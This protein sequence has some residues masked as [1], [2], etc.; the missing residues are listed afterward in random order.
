MTA[1]PAGRLLQVLGVW[2]GIAAIIGN[3]IGIGIMRT[4]SD[5]AHNLPSTGAYL[6]AWI[7]GGIY[8]AL[9]AAS[10]AELGVM[11]PRSGGQYV[12]AAEVFGPYAGFV[13]GWTDWLSTAASIAAVSMAMSE[14]AAPFVAISTEHAW[15][16]AVLT[17]IVIT[18]LLWRGTKSSDR[19]VQIMTL[20]K[21]IALV[22]VPLVAFAM[23]VHAPSAVSPAAE[24]ARATPAFGIGAVVLAMQ[25]VIYSYDGWNGVLYFSGEVTDPARDI[26]RSMLGGVGSVMAIYLLL[27][28]SFVYVLGVDGVAATNFPAGAVAS[29]L[30]GARGD[31]VIRVVVVLS[32]L[33]ALP[34]L[35]LMGSRVPHAMSGDGLFP[36]SATRVSE[37]GTPTVTL[38]ITL[39]VSIAFVVSGTF[40]QAIAIAAFFFVLQYAMSFTAV[41]VLRRRAPDRARPYRAIGY[42][43]TTA[44]SLVGALAFLVGA[45]VQDQRNSA[46][47]L[48]LL[49][50]SYPV[51]RLIR[52]AMAA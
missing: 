19:L 45:V 16:L 21:V 25:A 37:R 3:S 15:T 52:R 50:V 35:L 42:P 47:S 14:Y 33:S 12:F 28:G 38:A 7:I 46:V 23:R 11:M 5:V 17:L 22:L 26:P 2:F 20:V 49:A 6:A 48:A 36:R 44:L 39:A 8:A 41:F 24:A 34:P 18:A 29:A 9:G 30:F 27:T 31:T 51:Y 1:R 43:I 13:F 32:A 40:N 4:P 10:M